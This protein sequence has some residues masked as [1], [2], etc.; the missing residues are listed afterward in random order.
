MALTRAVQ[1]PPDTPNVP[2]AT[3]IPAGGGTP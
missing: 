2:R 3:T 1:P